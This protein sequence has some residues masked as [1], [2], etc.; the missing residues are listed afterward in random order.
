[1]LT[2]GA[3]VLSEGADPIVGFEPTV[4]G[5]PDR[6][7]FGRHAHRHVHRTALTESHQHLPFFDTMF[8][9]EQDRRVD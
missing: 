4:P 9:A 3:F 2:S 8:K 7:E 5:V 6:G 1:M